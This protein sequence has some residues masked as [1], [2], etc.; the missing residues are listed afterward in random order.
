M[1]ME[2]M[3]DYWSM[4]EGVFACLHDSKRTNALRRAIKNSIKK[5]DV[6]LELGA[7][8]GILSMFAADAGASKVYAVEL[9]KGNIDTLEK[10]VFE[11]GYSKI[12]TVIHNDATTVEI[13]EKVDYIICEM[14]AT[15]LI[16]ELQVPAMNNALRFLKPKGGVL[17]Q[18]YDIF[19]ELVYSKSEFYNKKFN[20]I[21]FELPEMRDMRSISFSEKISFSSNNFLKA[22]INSSIKKNIKVQII[23]NGKINAIRITGRTLLSDK[24]SLESSTAYDFPIILP[25]EER[26]VKKGEILSLKISYTMC[27]GV[28]T[29]DYDIR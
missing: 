9:D 7:G 8:T 5:G 22:I 21:R 14:I 28:R 17:I 13:P 4:N 24:T 6:V 10:V 1:N 3:D 15:G 25:L 2:K 29:L 26:E 20:I 12:I 27:E 18:Q 11:N 16:E 19:A 23:S